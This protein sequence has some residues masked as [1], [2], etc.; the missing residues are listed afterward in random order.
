MKHAN[1]TT[2]LVLHAAMALPVLSGC[3]GAHPDEKTA[4]YAALEKN[5]LSSVMV[6]EDRRS[7]VLTLT[8]IVDDDGRRTQA[9]SLARQAAPGYTIS[10][11]IQVRSTGLEG[12]AK[13]PHPAQ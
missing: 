8:G 4:V 9:E 3:L 6:A 5:D 2:I 12:L 11:R 1:S 13:A 7:G 10:D